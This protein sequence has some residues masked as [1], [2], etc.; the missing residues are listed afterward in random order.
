MSTVVLVQGALILVVFLQDVGPD[1]Y[2]RNCAPCHGPNGQ[3][4]K[5]PSLRVLRSTG[6]PAIAAII[7]NGVPGAAMPSFDFNQDQLL[8]LTAHVA[9]FS[10]G[11]NTEG[12]Q[13]AGR[14]AALVRGKGGCLTC[15]SVHGEGG[16]T[17]PDLSL[18]GARRDPA[19]L[20]ASL[21]DPANG[22]TD[23]YSLFHWYVRIK[24]DLRHVRVTLPD[25][26]A[27]EGARLNEDSFSVQFRDAGGRIHSVDKTS[28][29]RVETKPGRQVMPSYRDR[30]TAAE[31]EDV[32]VYLSSLR[33][34]L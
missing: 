6:G 8:A 28:G 26:R 11:L 22:I 13:R 31:L 5:G 34:R 27:L 1:L 7:T 20:R 14:G 19:E 10:A 33:G 2:R 23:R 18:V 30:F 32:V 17:G 21:L 12:Q 3:G 4:G 24:D 29:A 25:G 15:H 9:G 16:F